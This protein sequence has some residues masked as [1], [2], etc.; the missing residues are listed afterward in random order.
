MA[1]SNLIREITG[2]NRK[3]RVGR[4]TVADGGPRREGRALVSS[5]LMMIH[6]VVAVLVALLVSL[7]LV[8]HTT[9]PGSGIRHLMSGV[10]IST[11][12]GLAYLAWFIMMLLVVSLALWPVWAPCSCAPPFMSRG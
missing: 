5:A 10:G 6:D 7:Y 1:S 9:P 12:G 2:S 3:T 11:S 8:S 4:M